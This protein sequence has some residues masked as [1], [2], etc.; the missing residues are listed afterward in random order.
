M[1]RRLCI[2]LSDLARETSLKLPDNDIGKS[3]HIG[4]NIV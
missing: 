2:N 4:V 3:K 1:F